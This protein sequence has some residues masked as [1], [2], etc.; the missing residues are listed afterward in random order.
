[1]KTVV[2]LSGGID[3]TVMAYSFKDQGRTLYGFSVDYGQAHVKELQAAARV[4]SLVCEDWVRVAI[5]PI[6]APN[7]L[8]GGGGSTT[9]PARNLVF[10]SMALAYG[11]AIGADEVAIGVTK[12]DAK[13]FND[14]RPDF[15]SAFA[16]TIEEALGPGPRPTL[17]CPLIG[18]SKAEVVA[19][20]RRLGVP[21]NRTWSCYGN[22]HEPCG[23]C[24][25]CEDRAAAMGP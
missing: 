6:F 13:R 7:A 22:E 21:L 24:T 25:A 2:L 3:S 16:D 1:M 14:C 15:M 11:V 17:R 18:S 10:L 23:R 8:T 5:P 9:V 19:L 20:G 12:D 4:A